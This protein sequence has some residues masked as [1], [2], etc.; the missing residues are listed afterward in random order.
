MFIAVS[1]SIGAGKSTVTRI[2]AEITGFQPLF[3]T[4][5]GHPYL[6][7]FYKNPKKY[8]F[9]TQ[10]FFLWDRFN[11]HYNSMKSGKDIVADRS[12]YEDGIFAKVLYLRKEMDEDE[13][14]KTY[15]PHFKTLTGIV[16]QPDLMIYLSASLDTLIYRIRKRAR[17][18]E[19]DIDINYL[20]M[21]SDAYNEWIQEYPYRK[22]IIETDGLDLTCDLHTDWL[23]L[24]KAIVTKINRSEFADEAGGIKDLI[25]RMPKIHRMKNKERVREEIFK[26]ALK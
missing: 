19:K 7:K 21:L 16:E 17:D 2:L 26:G 13:Y 18:M 22:L 20:S 10:A 15:L 8:S 3:E 25:S 24:V 6:E 9:K 14:L 12:I 4:V 1:G 11:K 23:Y 5:E